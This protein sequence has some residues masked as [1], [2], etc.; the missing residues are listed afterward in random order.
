MFHNLK[1]PSGPRKQALWTIS[2]GRQSLENSWLGMIDQFARALWLE[3]NELKFVTVALD[4]AIQ[5]VDRKIDL[6][7]HVMC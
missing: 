6:D 2:G 5:D 3:R 7:V 1:S 4:P